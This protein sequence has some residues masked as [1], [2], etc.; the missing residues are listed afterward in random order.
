VVSSLSEESQACVLG[1]IVGLTRRKGDGRRRGF[2]DHSLVQLTSCRV[3]RVAE[4]LFG[5]NDDEVWRSRK[6][7]R[8]E[9][10]E[11]RR[12]GGGATEGRFCNFTTLLILCI[13]V[14]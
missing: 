11:K 3:A 6:S 12:G 2:I 7:N 8:G 4:S 10:E 9:E 1:R 5:S 14:T 13:Y